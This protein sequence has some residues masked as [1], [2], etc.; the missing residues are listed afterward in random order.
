MPGDFTPED[1]DRLVDQYTSTIRNEVR[2]RLLS[3]AQADAHLAEFYS[4][5][6]DQRPRA[7]LRSRFRLVDAQ[8]EAGEVSP[9]EADALRDEIRTDARKLGLGD[10]PW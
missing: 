8:A 6:R 7:V 10:P 1:W 9:D 2:L 5:A 3:P 4:V